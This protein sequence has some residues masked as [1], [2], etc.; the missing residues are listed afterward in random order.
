MSVPLPVSM[1]MDAAS[2]PPYDPIDQANANTS[3]AIY[4]NGTLLVNPDAKRPT[5]Y[6]QTSA[7]PQPQPQQHSRPTSPTSTHVSG[8]ENDPQAS[9]STTRRAR[10]LPPIPTPQP[11]S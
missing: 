7:P 9:Q 6:L 1:P 3:P 2:P 8:S 11:P 5:Y 4:P 10:P